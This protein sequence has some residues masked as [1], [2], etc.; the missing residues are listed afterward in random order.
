MSLLSIESDS[1]TSKNTEYGYLTGILY[2]APYTIGHPQNVCA[3]AGAAGCWEP[4]LFEAGMGKFPNVRDARVKRKVMFVEQREKFLEQLHKEIKALIKRSHK[5]GLKPCIRLNGTSDIPWHKPN[6]GAIP[7]QYPD[8]QF[9][10][11]TKTYKNYEDRPDNYYVI[12]SFSKAPQYLKHGV[13]NDLNWSVVFDG[14]LPDEFAGRSVISGDIHDL[15]FLDPNGVV[16]GLKAK[17]PAIGSSSPLV[18]RINDY[19]NREYSTT[20]STIV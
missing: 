14:D 3:M 17:G 4:C 10:D 12:W 18:V 5:R 1:K 20:D 19:E 6:F 7:Q 9:Y 13:P 11:Y 2:M 16:V 8:V 15:R